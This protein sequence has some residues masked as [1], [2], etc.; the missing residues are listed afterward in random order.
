MLEAVAGLPNF[1]TRVQ[2]MQKIERA[3][4]F[5]HRPLCNRLAARAKHLFQRLTF[6]VLESGAGGALTVLLTFLHARVT[7][8]KTGF[9]Q[10][11]S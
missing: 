6:A 2:R 9:F 11:G 3:G 8:E 10:H 4:G 7:C 1:W 5:P